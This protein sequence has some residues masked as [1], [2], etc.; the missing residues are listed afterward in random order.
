MSPLLHGPSGC[1]LAPVH[2]CCC[3]P[4][5][6]ARYHFFFIRKLPPLRMQAFQKLQP[7]STEPPPAPVMI[8]IPNRAPFYAHFFS[9]FSLHFSVSLFNFLFSESTGETQ[10]RRAERAEPLQ[11][12][13]IRPPPERPA[14]LGN[15]SWKPVRILRI[16]AK[17]SPLWPPFSRFALRFVYNSVTFRFVE[18][19]Y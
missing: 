6:I 18:R 15:R 7:G 4:R 16:V 1:L 14:S 13:R 19:D 10:Q 11:R 2:N 9:S 5:V 3:Y 17:P 12:R 8:T